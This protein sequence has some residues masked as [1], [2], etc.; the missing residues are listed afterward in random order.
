MT[1]DFYKEGGPIP[2]AGLEEEEP[3]SPEKRKREELFF[4]GMLGPMDGYMSGNGM[5]YPFFTPLLLDGEEEDE[6]PNP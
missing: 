2:F 5:A 3:E 6:D 4:S 1:S